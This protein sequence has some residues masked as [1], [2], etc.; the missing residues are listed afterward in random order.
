LVV[1]PVDPVP[2]AM[3]FEGTAATT[4]LDLDRMRLVP[5]AFGPALPHSVP[6]LLRHDPAAVAGEIQRLHYD[7]H[8]NLRIRA[9]VEHPEARR[10]SAFSVGIRIVECELHDAGSVRFHGVLKR[11]ELSEVSITD[12]PS[13][14]CAIVE[15]RI[16]A[17][18]S[19]FYSLMQQRVQC[20]GKYLQLVGQHYAAP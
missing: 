3:I 5:F 11:V 2:H 20:L 16:P 17:A 4:D 1:P 12:R 7:S 6:L 9:R 19:D 10:M 18:I 14:P 15:Q 8:G 13:N